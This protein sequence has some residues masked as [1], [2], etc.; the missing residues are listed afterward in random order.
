MSRLP[1]FLFLVAFGGACGGADRK[2]TDTGVPADVVADALLA[3]DTSPETGAPDVPANDDL[4]TAAD[5][6][7]STQ[8]GTPR[9]STLSAVAR[10]KVDRVS[11]AGFS[12]WTADRYRRQLST[13][14]P[15][16]SLVFAKT[17]WDDATGM[18]TP[19]GS[20]RD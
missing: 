18:A 8:C 1:I 12:I 14:I 2:S 20:G 13:I 6:S 4:P 10:T 5:A 11:T 16:S 19:L 15:K 9:C 3:T 7:C 17:L